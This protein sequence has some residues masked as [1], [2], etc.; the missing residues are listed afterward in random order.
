M[1]GS[2]VALRAEPAVKVKGVHVH[3]SSVSTGMTF[4]LWVGFS[5]LAC[6]LVQGSCVTSNGKAVVGI[7]CTGTVMSEVDK[8]QALLVAQCA[9]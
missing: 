5:R 3:D 1:K 7:G 4:C 9:A 2:V 8:L 6:S